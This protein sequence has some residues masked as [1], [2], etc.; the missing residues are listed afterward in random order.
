MSTTSSATLSGPGMAPAPP[1]GAG[2]PPQDHDVL[3]AA[4]A[5][6]QRLLLEVADAL[7][8][9]RAERPAVAQRDVDPQAGALHR[10]GRPVEAADLGVHDEQD[11]ALTEVRRRLGEQPV[12]DHAA[13]TAGVP[14][15][16]GP[17]G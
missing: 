16:L 13:V 6:Q 9:Q 5:R 12:E 10:L 2:A 17:T 11:A 4:A 15:A 14:R 7:G 1:R 3:P 8:H